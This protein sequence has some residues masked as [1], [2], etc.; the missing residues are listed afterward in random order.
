MA[1]VRRCAAVRWTAECFPFS[2]KVPTR[3]M[4]GANV[5]RDRP[6]SS[7][8]ESPIDPLAFANRV[9]ELSIST[10]TSRS[11]PCAGTKAAFAAVDRAPR[12][13]SGENAPEHA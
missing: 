12:G 3:Y 6:A 5:C 7:T 10:P 11:A 9:Q 2:A 13:R 1:A 8:D 4:P